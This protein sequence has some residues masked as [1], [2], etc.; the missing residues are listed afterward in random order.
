VFGVAGMDALRSGRCRK[1][2]DFNNYLET[3]PAGQRIRIGKLFGLECRQSK[4]QTGFKAFQKILKHALNVTLERCSN[5]SKRPRY[6]IL[7]LHASKHTA[8][9]A[10]YAP[11]YPQ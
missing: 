6:F 4:T 10:K 11:T 2:R 9:E 5:S 3:Q 8:F 1:S 7:K